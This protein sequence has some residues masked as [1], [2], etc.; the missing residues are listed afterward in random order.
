MTGGARVSITQ[1]R[2]GRAQALAAYI[3]A[4]SILM[5]AWAVFKTWEPI[6]GRGAVATEALHQAERPTSFVPAQGAGE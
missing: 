6:Q 5:F 1:V 4:L 3:I 2:R